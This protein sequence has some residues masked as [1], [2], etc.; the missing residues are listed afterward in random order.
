MFAAKEGGDGGKSPFFDFPSKK[1]DGTEVA[2]LG[3]LVDGKKAILVVNVASEWGVTER[4]YTQ[5]VQIHKDYKDKGLEIL[6]FPCNQFGSQEPHDAEWI[7]DFVKKYDVAFP[8][9]EKISVTNKR[10]SPIY[11]W[12]RENSD[13]RGGDMQ[14]NFEKFLINAD[15]KIVGH[16]GAPDEPNLLKPEIDKLVAWAPEKNFWD[17]TKIIN[18][19]KD[20]IMIFGP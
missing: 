1:L 14:W 13:L 9:M 15:G 11:K 4:D 16:W 12:L 6:A 19:E 5:M 20:I 7:Q 8:M 10:Q 18:H 2:R 17:R 3:D